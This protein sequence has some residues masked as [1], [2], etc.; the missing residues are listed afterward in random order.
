MAEKFSFDDS[1]SFLQIPLIDEGIRQVF[2]DMKDSTVTINTDN[3]T[4][5]E[6]GELLGEIEERLESQWFDYTEPVTVSGYMRVEDVPSDKNEQPTIKYH[7]DEK[8]YAIVLDNREV[9]IGVPEVFSYITDD[10]TWH[11]Q[12]VALTV[13]FFDD[14]EFVVGYLLP[15]E[16]MIFQPKNPTIDG[17]RPRVGNGH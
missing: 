11:R 9:E 4:D 7:E 1:E 15:D 8:G 3:M 5:V 13:R 2:E 6:V 16:V 14:G 17:A 10:D 12:E